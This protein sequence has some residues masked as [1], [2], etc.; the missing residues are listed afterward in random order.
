MISVGGSQLDNQ[1][2]RE[3]MWQQHQDVFGSVAG[4]LADLPPASNGNG[5]DFVGTTWGNHITVA[6]PAR[7]IPVKEDTD[8]SF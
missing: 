1:T 6:A 3:E 4:W 5:N 2:N 8:P 7:D